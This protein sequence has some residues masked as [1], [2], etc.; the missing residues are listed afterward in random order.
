MTNPSLKSTGDDESVADAES[1][2]IKNS[3]TRQM[4]VHGGLF[5]ATFLSM[6]FANSWPLLSVS[7]DAFWAE[8]WGNG[9]LYATTLAAILGAHEM[10]HYVAARIHGVDVSLPFFI[11][12]PPPLIFGTFGAFIRMREPVTQRKALLDVGAA[13]PVCGFIVAVPALVLGLSLS[14]VKP[15][16]PE[17][18]Y[19]GNS[20]LYLFFKRLVLG[21]IPPGYDVFLHPIAW[22]AWIGLL[23]TAL[24]LFPVGQLDGGHVTYALWGPRRHAKLAEAAYGGLIGLALALVIWDG[25]P[26]W[27]LWVVLVTLLGIKHPPMGDP[28]SQ[29]GRWRSAVGWLCLLLFALS[30]SPI[31]LSTSPPDGSRVEEGS[32]VDGGR[33]NGGRVDGGYNAVF[34]HDLHGVEGISR[35]NKEA[36]DD[37]GG[38]ERHKRH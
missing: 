26:V 18:I 38:Y 32:R 37:P 29:L 28:E 30:F 35:S 10:G 14:E 34:S 9:L 8:F 6:M 16:T 7:S 27:V 3:F 20:L 2:Q 5:V 4:L 31:P 15:I 36:R 17:G 24:N 13:G 21:E 1:S 11:P 25:E 12:A 33:V 22:A 19:E 23:V